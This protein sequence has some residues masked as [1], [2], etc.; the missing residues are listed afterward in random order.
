MK[1]NHLKRAAQ[2]RATIVAT[3]NS[4][5]S[6]GLS[7]KDLYAVAGKGYT[8]NDNAFS[9]LLAWMVRNG[10]IMRTKSKP[11][12]YFTR[13]PVKVTHGET[14]TFHG[15]MVD[16]QSLPKTDVQSLPKTDGPPTLRVD[17]DRAT[18][19]VKL[20][21][22]GTFVIDWPAPSLTRSSTACCRACATPTAVTSMRR[23]RSVP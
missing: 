19:R 7:Y 17:V 13:K 15:G 21:V 10:T 4:H 8:R 23:R 1:N 16:L 9:S 6:G 14:R 5:G 22:T 11:Y 3:L 2:A 18:G 20:T 12:A